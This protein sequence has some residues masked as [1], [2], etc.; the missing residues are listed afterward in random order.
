MV[1]ILISVHNTNFYGEV[2]T[3]LTKVSLLASGTRGYLGH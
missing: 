1:M 3:L 2:M